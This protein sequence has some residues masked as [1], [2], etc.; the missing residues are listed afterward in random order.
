MGR[1]KFF[2]ENQ[3][4]PATRTRLRGGTLLDLDKAPICACT[5]YDLEDGNIGIVLPEADKKVPG[6]VIVNDEKDRTTTA[7]RIRWRMGPYL[8][9]SFLEEPVPAGSVASV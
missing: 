4:A 7:V 3:P 1:T 9:T 5:L 2:Q 8:F 6:K